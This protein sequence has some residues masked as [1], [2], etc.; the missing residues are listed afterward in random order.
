ML[1]E[2]IGFAFDR[3][4]PDFHNSDLLHA[5]TRGYR[6]FSIYS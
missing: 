5:T 1:S 6:C 3:S 4:N 2:A